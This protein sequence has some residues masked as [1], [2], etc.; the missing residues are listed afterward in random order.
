M[1]LPA[2][3]RQDSRTT[4]QLTRAA[5]GVTITNWTGPNRSFYYCNAQ[6]QGGDRIAKPSH[7]NGANT[8][9]SY[10]TIQRSP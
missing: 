1:G 3:M 5:S 9:P 7:G 6:P 2:F 10:H 4:H 8:P